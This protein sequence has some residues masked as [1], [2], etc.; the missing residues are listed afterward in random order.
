MWIV[1]TIQRTLFGF[2]ASPLI[3]IWTKDKDRMGYNPRLALAL[4][5]PEGDPEL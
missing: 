5:W 1:H 2:E 4:A 3:G